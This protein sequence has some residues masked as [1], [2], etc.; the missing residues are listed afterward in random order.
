MDDK[1]DK[2]VLLSD[3]QK[4]REHKEHELAFY[5]AQLNVYEQRL[6]MVQKEIQLTKAII[7]MIK[8]E[9]LVDISEYVKL[10]Q[11]VETDEDEDDFI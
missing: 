11:L 4:A 5:Y 9:R 8:K 10:T 6:V 1:P 3:L 2:I 7:D